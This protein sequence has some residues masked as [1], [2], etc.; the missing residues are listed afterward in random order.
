MTVTNPA[1]ALPPSFV[2]ASQSSAQTA[3]NNDF[4]NYL[5]DAISNQ[6]ALKGVQQV[7]S[8]TGQ[9]LSPK[10]L[11]QIAAS[12]IVPESS[13]DPR[14]KKKLKSDMDLDGA[15]AQVLPG[16]S[17]NNSQ[18][19]LSP[20]EF[21]YEIDQDAYDGNYRREALSVTPFQF[22]LDKTIDFFSRVTLMEIKADSLMEL[23]VRGEASLEELTIEKAKVSVAIS[24][25]TTV[26]S[27]VTQ[28]F[29]EI[30]NMQI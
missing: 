4:Q 3:G 21:N 11:A 25:A 24:F 19:Q 26:L 18:A 7:I 28:A 10:E 12:L 29:K 30:Q 2:P 27:Q 9:A 15:V 16:R 17:V 20:S 5:K 14:K 13:S 23:Y 8:Q 6:D 1:Q 22:F